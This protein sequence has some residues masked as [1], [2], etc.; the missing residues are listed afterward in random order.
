[1]A[2][3]MA[4]NTTE[5]IFIPI[6]NLLDLSLENTKKGNYRQ[7]DEVKPLLLSLTSLVK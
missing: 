1:M 5:N 3:A 2:M 7:K 4:I 6:K